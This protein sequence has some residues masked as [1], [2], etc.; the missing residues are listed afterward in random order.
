MKLGNRLCFDSILVRLKEGK[1][2]FWLTTAQRFR[3]HTGSIK[4]ATVR[5]RKKDWPG[6]RFHTGSIKRLGKSHGYI[7]SGPCGMCQVNYYITRFEDP[8][9]VDQRS[10]KFFGSSTDPRRT[11]SKWLFFLKK[12]NVSLARNLKFVGVDSKFQMDIAGRECI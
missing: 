10:C 5:E 3:F 2:A 8:F 7:V 1:T 11:W 4:S 9:A 12:V 6:F